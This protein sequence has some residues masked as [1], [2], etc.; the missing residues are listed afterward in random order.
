MIVAT[1]AVIVSTTKML[2]PNTNRTVLLL[3]M[4]NLALTLNEGE[5]VTQGDTVDRCNFST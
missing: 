3:G 5:R 1:N 2:G 4:L